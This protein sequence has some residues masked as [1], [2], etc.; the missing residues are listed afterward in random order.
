MKTIFIDSN[1]K[2]ISKKERRNKKFINF[3][4]GDDKIPAPS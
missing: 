4:Q 3:F 1:K 2:N